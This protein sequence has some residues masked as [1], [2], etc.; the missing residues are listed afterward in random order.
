M[1]SNLKIQQLQLRSFRKQGYG[2]RK[3]NAI[4]LFTNICPCF[5]RFFVLKHIHQEHIQLNK[6]VALF[7]KIMNS[8]ENM[9]LCLCLLP[10][11]PHSL[12]KCDIFEMLL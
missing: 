11:R 2:K 9:V 8:S 7:L 4:K 3:K 10:D 1:A 5:V 6:T 12:N